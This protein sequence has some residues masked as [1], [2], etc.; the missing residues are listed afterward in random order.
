MANRK[1]HKLSFNKH[2]FEFLK[3]EKLDD[4]IA[5]IPRG[6]GTYRL[7]WRVV[8]QLSAE[9]L[10]EFAFKEMEDFTNNLKECIIVDI[11]GKE[12]SDLNV[13]VAA[14]RKERN[15]STEESWWGQGTGEPIF[16][17]AMEGVREKWQDVAQAGDNGGK[18]ESCEES[19]ALAFVEDMAIMY[20]EALGNQWYL[21]NCYLCSCWSS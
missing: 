13:S 9:I 16:G 12:S 20:Q 17:F 5:T 6:M 7:P 8:V 15:T 2:I 10:A 18:S 14:P 21:E 11:P 3:I 1:S 19:R 4:A